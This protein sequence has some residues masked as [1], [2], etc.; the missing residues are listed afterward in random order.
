MVEQG[1]RTGTHE[2][3]RE[4]RQGSAA[5]IE[6]PRPI[7]TASPATI[8]PA[9]STVAPDRP[10]AKSNATAGGRAERGGPP[11]VLGVVHPEREVEKNVGTAREGKQREHEADE[12]R[13]DT[14]CRREPAADVVTMRS[15][16]LR[17]NG[18]AGICHPA[19][20]TSMWPAPTLAS[21]TRGSRC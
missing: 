12:R 17:S 4:D 19:R 11:H 2:D 20:T 6:P 21:M 1:D 14:E 15:C 7:S 13:V 16:P 10:S 3:D 18:S 9:P 5:R 8:S